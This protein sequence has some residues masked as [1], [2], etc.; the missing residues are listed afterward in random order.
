[1]KKDPQK[2]NKYKVY[3]S[4]VKDKEK[5]KKE[6]SNLFDL[7]KINILFEKKLLTEE[8]YRKILEKISF[9]GE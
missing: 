1:M 9:V 3:Y 8:E 6:I 2:S 4:E 5:F 7:Y